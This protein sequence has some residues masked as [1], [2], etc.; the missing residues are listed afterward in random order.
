MSATLTERRQ[1]WVVFTR[2]DDPWLA[3]ETAELHRQGGRVIRLNGA[4]L[5]EPAALF[6]AFAR[7]LRFPPYFGHN[8]D[9]LVDCLHDWHGH[10][11]DTRDAAILIDRADGLLGAEFLGCFVSVLCQEAWRANLQLDADGEADEDTPPFTLHVVLALTNTPPAAFAAA[12]EQGMDVAVNHE[13]GRLTATLTG[14]D[15][16]DVAPEPGRRISPPQEP[17]DKS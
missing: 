1:P 12:A 3:A 17:P 11:G 2:H 7:E 8:W 16:P 6:T 10:G 4:E 14:A 15:W 5:H 9:A 13:E